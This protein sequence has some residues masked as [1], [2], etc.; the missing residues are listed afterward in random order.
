M[1]FNRRRVALACTFCR[2][3]KRRCDAGRPACRNCIE[4]DVDC[5]Y[6]DTPS[7]RIDSSGGS[8]EIISRLQEIEAM[9]QHHL[10]GI[11]ALVSGIQAIVSQSPG[12]IAATSPASQAST[13]QAARILSHDLAGAASSPSWTL[14]SLGIEPHHQLTAVADPEL[15]PLT[16]PVGH[17][18]SSN[19]LL[20]LPA[21]KQL[22]GEYP[23]DLFFL[24]ES[25]NTLPTELPVQPAVTPL[26][27]A[28][29]D[30]EYLDCLLSAFFSHAYQCHPI[31]DKDEFHRIYQDFLKNYFADPCSIESV[32]CLVVFAIGAATLAPRGAQGFQTSP[33]GMV[34]MQAAL[35]TLVT[36]SSWS[37]SYNLLLPQALVLASVYFAYIIRPLQ[38]WR[39]V[40]S[41]SS[42]LQFKLCRL[43]TRE[44]DPA[45]KETILRIFWS[46]FLVECDRLAELELPQSGLQQLIDQTSLPSFT[47]VDSASSTAY[48]AEISIRRLLNRVH[49]SLYPRKQNPLSLSS[50]SL[51]ALDDFSATEIASATSVCGELQRQLTLWYE[52]IPAPFRPSLGTEATGSDRETVLR[53]RYYAARHIIHRPFLLYI[54][55]HDLQHVSDPGILEKAG[56]CIESCRAYLH[57][58]TKIL[59]KQS[60]YTWTFSLS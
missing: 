53:I 20:R 26:T 29:L 43:S 51:T 30:K 21:M 17:K 32:L 24:L 48:L 1:S 12:G 18:T 25:R 57:N 28:E 52:S 23:E 56:V 37:V 50:T 35:P 22:I 42:L 60:Q 46:C 14:P 13:L 4:A 54:V 55:T 6:D 38:S 31:L 58:T 45:S 41:A 47:S 11:S 36:M 3:R 27:S 34:Y 5:R 33:P 16:I 39:L 19:Y 49:N 7:Q 15:A 2:H 40:Y 59:V 10:P 9:L 44:D 8:R